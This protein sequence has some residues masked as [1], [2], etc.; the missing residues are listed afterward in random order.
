MPIFSGQRRSLLRVVNEVKTS[1]GVLLLTPM[2]PHTAR[3]HDLRLE[4]D[5]FFADPPGR[6]YLTV[7]R[8]TSLIQV[9]G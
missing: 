5:Q 1:G 6:G 8:E 9:A 3:E 7:G 4:A 2:S